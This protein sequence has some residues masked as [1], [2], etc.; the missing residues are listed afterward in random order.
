MITAEQFT[1]P[2][3]P[4]LVYDDLGEPGSPPLVLLHGGTADRSS[5]ADLAANVATESRVL[6]P[7]LRG[8]GESD[9][10]PGEYDL[11]HFTADIEGFV[12]QVVGQPAVV[13]GHSLGAMVAAHLASS[14]PD[15]VDGAFL[16]DP[17][18]YIGSEGFESMGFAAFF[19]LLRQLLNDFRARQGTL[20]ELVEL[21]RE[22]PNAFGD[23][24]TLGGS[25]SEDHL[26]RA[27]TA[28]IR[29]DTSVLDDLDS[30]WDAY[31]PSVPVA[32]PVHLLRA[33][34][35]PAFPAEH[36]ARF[37]ATHP[38]ATVELVEGTTHLIPVERPD[39]VLAALRAFLAR[40]PVERAGASDG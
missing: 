8:H 35:V 33:E 12:E 2:G 4:T 36:E 5:W 15:L 22:M 11:A 31:D 9:R 29:F 24:G 3:R 28:W 26:V 38:N 14:R 30:T 13:A 23:G 34:H 19:P 17:P 6:V 40:C 7:D 10:A 18:I 27:A 32:C 39:R 25:F 16:I 21:M 20:E 37:V 1:A